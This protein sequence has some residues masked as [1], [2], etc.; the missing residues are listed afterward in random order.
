MEFVRPAL[1]NEYFHIGHYIHSLAAQ[2]V[3][4]GHP[5]LI[6]IFQQWSKWPYA[7]AKYTEDY[8]GLEYKFDIKESS[9]N[10]FNP[11]L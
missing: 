1:D 10:M 9:G 2:I 6:K 5:E 7:S 11:I 3:F 4:M 8:P